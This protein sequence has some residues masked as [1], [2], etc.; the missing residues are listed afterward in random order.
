MNQEKIGAFIFQ[1]R[2]EKNLT[3]E[4]VAEK[5]GVTSKSVSRWENGRTLPD[6]SMLRMLA[7]YMGVSLDELLNG[8]R[9]VL[10]KKKMKEV[11]LFYL[12]VSFTG[13]FVF[14]VLG[15][16][17]PAFILL[18]VAVPVLGFIS[19]ILSFVGVEIPYFIVQVGPF[20]PGPV[21]SF[22]I[23]CL[24]SI[25]LYLG[26]KSLWKLLL[27]YVHYIGNK[28]KKLNN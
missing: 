20:I 27:K 5:M 12:F 28:F 13:L 19:L 10:K 15:F 2:K 6:V 26:G 9:K 4:Q 25:P 14:P 17:A 16:V 11:I 3:Q 21:L 1:L 7:S 8:E 22:I 24:V 18:S 23:S